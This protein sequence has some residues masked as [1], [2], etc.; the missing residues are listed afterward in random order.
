M[1]ELNAALG[2]DVAPFD[3]R[4]LWTSKLRMYDSVR[5]QG[6]LG[7]TDMFNLAGRFDRRW[8]WI[9]AL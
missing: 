8:V 5:G 3:Q 1:L 4:H 6:R 2:T 7:H 9:Y